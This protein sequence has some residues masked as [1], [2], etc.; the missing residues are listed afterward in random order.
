VHH[1]RP[2]SSRSCVL[3]LLE[4]HTCYSLY[5]ST[6]LHRGDVHC[7][8]TIDPS[9]R[10]SKSVTTG[11]EV[12]HQCRAKHRDYQ[13]LQWGAIRTPDVYQDHCSCSNHIHARSEPPIHTNRCHAIL[14][15]Q[16][17]CTGF[18]V[19]HSSC[20]DRRQKHRAG[21]HD[22]L[23]R[24]NG[25]SGHHGVLTTI[26]RAPKGKT[27]GREI[28]AN[29]EPNIRK[30]SAPRDGWPTKA[31]SMSRRYRIPTSKLLYSHV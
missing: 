11:T 13:V 22:I 31:S 3:L 20:Q 26:Y 5:R 15:S 7:A 27:C 16:C 6:D 1:P 17:L 28:A 25:S 2:R 24:S 30:R 10:A 29:Y 9:K 14:H 18:L 23:G 19:W 21:H 12:H 8:T 4:P